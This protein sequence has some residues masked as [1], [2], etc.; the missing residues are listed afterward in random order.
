LSLALLLPLRFALCQPSCIEINPTVCRDG[1]PGL[2]F[3][4]FKEQQT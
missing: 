3:H 4:A 2:Y 1:W